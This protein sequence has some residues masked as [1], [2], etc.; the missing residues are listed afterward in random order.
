MQGAVDAYRRAIDSGHADV[1]QMAAFNVGGVLWREG[2]VQ[3]AK[4]AY[5][6]AIDSG[7]DGTAPMAAVKLG[8]L[9]VGAGGR[10]E[11]E[12]RLSEGAGQSEA[13][14]TVY[15][16]AITEPATYG[17]DAMA[18]KRRWSDLDESTR[19]LII[20]VAVAEGILK[21]AALIDIKRRPAS[22]IRGPK[23]LWAPW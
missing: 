20:T 3:G 5:K 7:C 23:W 14:L 12:G 22:Q 11:R 2:D 17:E 9:L 10:A 8:Y 21:V 15:R 1:A 16:A 4:D 6:K 18:A 19:K 13:C